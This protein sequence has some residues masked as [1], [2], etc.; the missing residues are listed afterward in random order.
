MMISSSLISVALSAT[1]STF[2]FNDDC[3]KEFSIFTENMKTKNYEYAMPSFRYLINNCAE[4]G[5]G[6]Y[7]RGEELLNH[8]ISKEKNESVKEGL[9]DTL[10]ILLDK[11]IEISKNDSKYGKEGFIIGKKANYYA[12]H[13]KDQL[14]VIYELSKKSVEIEGSESAASVMSTYMQYTAILNTKEKLTCDDV[15]NVYNLLSE[16]ID[17]NL[18]RYEET[19]TIKYANNQKAQENV[20]KLAGACLTCDNLVDILK[21]SFEANKTNPV[22]VKRTVDALDRKKCLK[23]EQYRKEDLVL[24]LFDV[25]VGFNP[26]SD[27]YKKLARMHVLMGNINLAQTNYEKA[28]ELAVQNEDK[29]QLYMEFALTQAEKGQYSQARNSARNAAKLREN[30][31]K[32]YLFIGDLYAGSASRCSVGNPCEDRAVF[33]AAADKYIYAKSIDPSCS[34]EANRK[35]GIAAANYPSKDNCFFDGFKEGQ[36]YTVGCWI[37]ESTTVRIK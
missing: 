33:W 35:L 36:S 18:K 34:D 4:I 3:K 19:D 23:E 28:I 5:T 1:L 24:Q 31:G 32:P 2:S 17:D 37:S 20:D 26:S 25:N 6:L 14:E 13:R 30:W 15:I 10:F 16:Y 27:G 9:I 7:I 21:R 29:A 11:R 12:L 22:W 8:F